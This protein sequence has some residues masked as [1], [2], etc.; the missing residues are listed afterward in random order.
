MTSKI[1]IAINEFEDKEGIKGTHE[2]NLLLDVGGFEGPIDVLLTLARDQKVD[3]AQISILELSNQYLYWVTEIRKSNL[4]LAADYLVMA[5]WLAYLKSRLLIPDV[6]AEDEPTGE[7]MSEALQFQLQRLESMQKSGTLI[8]TRLQLGKDYFKR[9][10]PEKFGYNSTSVFEMSIY[11]LLSA[12]GEHTHRSNVK[13]LHIQSSDL[14]SPDDA[15]QRMANLIDKFADWALLEQF[16]P[17]ELRGDI[18]SRSAIASTFVAALQ[19][20]KEGKMQIRQSSAFEPIFIRGL[21]LKE[22][23][24]KKTDN[25]EIDV[26]VKPQ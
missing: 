4:E 15:I 3:L 6:S 24:K 7:E 9:G 19:M 16:L 5:A 1:D 17:I 13:T 23:H 20:A 10:A 22:G 21:G 11:D 12:Y 18:I 2:P 25:N 14:F 26:R 8:M